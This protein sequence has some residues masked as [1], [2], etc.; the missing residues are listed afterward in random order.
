MPLRK[1]RFISVYPE[2][3]ASLLLRQQSPAGCRLGICTNSV[4][5]KHIYQMYETHTEKE[6][7]RLGHRKERGKPPV[8]AGSETCTS[9]GVAGTQISAEF[10]I[11]STVFPTTPGFLALCIRNTLRASL[12]S[13]LCNHFSLLGSLKQARHVRA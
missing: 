4:P 1:E 12:R 3:L 11:L 8:C 9:S 13:A 7:T 10:R 2:I 5:Y 6:R